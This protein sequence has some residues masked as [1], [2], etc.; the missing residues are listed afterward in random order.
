MSIACGPPQSFP[1]DQL[2][3]ILT[4]LYADWEKNHEVHYV[5]CSIVESLVPQ[6][7]LNS[8]SHV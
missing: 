7:C 1:L 4:R 3:L 5:R 6:P 8:Q 2:A